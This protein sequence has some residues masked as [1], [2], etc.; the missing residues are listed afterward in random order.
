MRE[1][2]VRLSGIEPGS[3]IADIGCGKGV[4]LPHLLK[5]QP[6]KIL[7]VDI[8][9]KMLEYAKKAYQDTRIEFVHED[10]MTAQLQQVDVALMYNVYPHFMNKTMLAERI[11]ELVRPGGVA[12]V[13]HGASKERINAVHQTGDKEKHSTTLRAAEFEANLFS[14][15]FKTAQIIDNSSLYFIKLERLL[16]MP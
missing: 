6:G 7:A 2:I 4:M 3:I 16:S 15:Y 1:E 5:T 11:A 8:S 9:A 13:G 12:V 14:P 10:I